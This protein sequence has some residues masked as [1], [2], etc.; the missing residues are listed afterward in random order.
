MS[1]LFPDGFDVACCTRA[2]LA[3]TNDSVNERNIRIQQMNYQQ[4]YPFLY[5]VNWLCEVD[6]PNDH[7]KNILTSAY[8]RGTSTNPQDLPTTERVQTLALYWFVINVKT[9]GD[10]ESVPYIP[11]IRIKFRRPYYGQS[12]QLL[13][14]QFPSRLAYAVAINK[15]L[16]QELQR[17]VC[18]FRISPFAAGMRT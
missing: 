3:V 13:R 16:G 6:Y 7:Q 4:T 11:R 14:T 10:R 9:L 17:V 5:S 12:Y 2:I 18:D 15:A 8:C 1:F